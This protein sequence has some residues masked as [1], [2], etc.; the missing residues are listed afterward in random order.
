MAIPPGTH[1]FGPDNAELLVHTKRTGAATVRQT[2][3]GLKPYSI[4]FGTLKVADEVRIT[5]D[6]DL[7]RSDEHGS[8]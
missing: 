3:L 2:D 4:L 7:E 5:I 1:R 6:A 8:A